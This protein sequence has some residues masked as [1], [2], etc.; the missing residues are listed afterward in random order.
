MPKGKIPRIPA[1]QALETYSL[2][3]PYGVVTISN[4]GRTVS[5]SLF[6][7]IRQSEH[8]TALYNYVQQLKSRGITQFNNDHIPIAGANRGFILTR[9]KAKLDIVYFENGTI[10]EVELKTSKQIG[11]ERAQ[12]QLK[13]MS[14]YCTNLILA[15]KRADYEEALTILNII[16]LADKIK[17]DTYDTYEEKYADFED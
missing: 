3:T 5:F 12:L 9:G 17:V 16:G 7:D 4:R 2:A 8:H 1:N 10:H 6:E 15:V 13:E 14:K 11:A